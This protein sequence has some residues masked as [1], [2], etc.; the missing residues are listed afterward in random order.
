[1]TAPDPVAIAAGIAE[2]EHVQD[3]LK[4]AQRRIATGRPA[5]AAELGIAL[6]RRYGL[7]ERPPWQYRSALDRIVRLLCLSPGTVPEAVRL[8]TVI[9][10]GRPV[11][12][13][14]A[15]LA[16]GHQPEELGPAL[17]GD[18]PGELRACLVHELA[19][20]GRPVDV[21]P[22]AGHPLA[23]LPGALTPLEGR[24]AMPRYSLDGTGGALP[25]EHST[26][27]A[28]AGAVPPLRETT[29]EDVSVAIEAA[30][31]NWARES[32]GQVESRTYEL[33]AELVPGAAAATLRGLGLECFDGLTTV[34]AGVAGNAW[35]QLFTAASGGGA[36]SSG[37]YGAYGRLA[38]W[39]SIGALA[40]APPGATAGETEAAALAAEWY[41]FA[42][43]SPWFANVAWDIGLAAVSAGGRRLALLAATDTD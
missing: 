11:R 27:L 13:A 22:P 16:G 41:A 31:R 33:G 37:E 20:R 39:R 6:W 29:T 17:G 38:A 43:A 12:L 18:A 1:M 10:E 23:W 28:E 30:V 21:A 35:R 3:V 5:F 9:G 4:L 32:N 40:G 15:L 7:D 8:S 24:P 19:L 2:R 36:Y 25:S 26:V 42:G 14:A 34:G